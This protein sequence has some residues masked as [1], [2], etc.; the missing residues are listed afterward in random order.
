MIFI[1]LSTF[2]SHEMTVTSATFCFCVTGLVSPQVT[3]YTRT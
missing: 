1:S 2:A 3:V